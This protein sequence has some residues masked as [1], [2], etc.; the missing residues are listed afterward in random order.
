MKKKYFFKKSIPAFIMLIIFAFIGMEIFQG[1][2]TPN[3]IN[4]NIFNY[5]E[6]DPY[7]DRPTR[8]ALSHVTE[9]SD[10]DLDIITDANGFD[11]FEIGV[12]F[13]EQMLVSN[14]LNPLNMQFGVNSGSGQNAYYT[15]NGYD[16]TQSNPSYNASICCDPWSAWDG[17]GRLVYGS[18]VSGQYVYRS[19]TGATYTPVG[20]T[21]SVSG[22]DRNTLAAEQTGTGPY[23]NY[24]YAAITPGNFARS[25]DGGV[26]WATTYSPSNTIP[27]V[28][29]AVG[30]NG[31][32]NGGCVM[33]V[34]NTGT[35]AN[36]TYTFHRSLDGGAT[37]T[38]RSAINP[39]GYVGTL[40]TAGRLVINNGRTRPYPMIA[41]DNSSG[42]YRGRLYLVY[43]SNVP[44]GNGNKPDIKLIYS[45]DQG[46]TWS[47]PVVVNDN[48]NPTLSDQ[49]FPSIWCEKTTGRLYIKWYDDR[50]NPATFAT[51]V[52]ATYSDNGGVSFPINQKLTT[53]SW[54]YPNPACAP[55]TNC[56]RGDY[57][58]MTANP[59]AGFAVWYD[60][61]LG[62]YKNVGSYFPDFGMLAT[63]ASNT[64]HQTNSSVNYLINIPAVKLYTDVTT[65]SA[66]V[67]PVQPGIQFEFLGGNTLSTYPNTKNLKVKTVGTVPIGAYTITIT[68]Q[69]SNGT[70]VHKRTVAL[71]VNTTVGPAPCESFVGAKFPPANFYEEYSGTNYWSRQTQTAYGIG[72]AGSARFNSWTAPSGTIQS[73]VTNNF[74]NAVANTYLTL[75]NAYRPWTF[76][77]S[78][79]DSLIIETSSNFG[80]SYTALERLWGGLGANAGP[81]NTVFV[82]GS[83]FTPSSRE[84]AP[85]IFLLPVGTNKVKLRAISG[86]GNDIWLDNICVQVLAAPIVNSIAIV[87]EG[88]FNCSF[89]FLKCND[90]VKVFLYR[91]D[92]PNIK[93]DSAVG[94]IDDF[95]FWHG[96]FTRALDGTYYKVMNHRNT[97]RT[98]SATG[99]G[100][101]RG[102]NTTYNF[103]TPSG[104]A[105]GNNQ[106]HMCLPNDWWAMFSGDV[107]KD[108]VIDG[109]DVAA[110]DN[111]A[112]NF[113]S[114]DVV[115]DLNCDDFVDGTDF[116]LAD[117]NA[118]DGVVEVAPPGA[119]PLD[120]LTKFDTESSIKSDAD[121]VTY[122]Q[123]LKLLETMKQD[124]LK[125]ESEKIKREELVKS[126]KTKKAKM[127]F[128]NRSNINS[129]NSGTQ[130]PGE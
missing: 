71:T 39:A 112:F 64:V 83:Q 23:A 72:I 105:F 50:E 65:F 102:V 7:I 14:P 114:G 118:F 70:P 19:T 51:N 98:W 110:I 63:P 78:N 21:L 120:R 129:D 54:T 121:K 11:N 5:D 75:D 97:I 36:V 18:G 115:T 116:A 125:T 48:V 6:N 103:I 74:P 52:Y 109:T 45:P 62:T 73:I 84:W 130:K 58:G 30:P 43:A 111:D 119:E 46:A 12:D 24:F 77:I 37:F 66:T 106:K 107:N 4:E 86:N 123:K 17:L 20:G 25:L 59:K 100:Y 81:L 101:T 127:D 92:F 41:M 94:I 10:D 28:M 87:P 38:V 2:K 31:A 29:I 35:T 79:I 76:G 8:E 15:T 69:G 53:T 99:L 122:E 96:T 55:N 117:N 42:P 128:E 47:V 67:S 91:A 93:V 113:V 33:Y 26:T 61:R 16:W 108:G 85:K 124:N 82:G 88:M 34:T 40:N 27:G 56:Y 44:A 80:G 95:A 1:Q 68:G 32:T 60:G 126:W 13:A 49:W 104:Q 90:T 57:D 22:N 9:K 89:P 3:Q